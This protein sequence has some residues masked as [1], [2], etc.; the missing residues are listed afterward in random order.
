MVSGSDAE[1]ALK[2]IVRSSINF[3]PRVIAFSTYFSKRVCISEDG[4]VLSFR[5][6]DTYTLS[7]KQFIFRARRTIND[8][9]EMPQMPGAL[10]IL[11][12]KS[13]DFYKD[14]ETWIPAIAKAMF[15]EET[16]DFGKDVERMYNRLYQKKK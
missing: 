6:D 7:P 3:P 11:T 8:L 12:W 16:H 4:T 5:S 14:L 1:K 9:R 15:P 2:Y 10:E 13:V